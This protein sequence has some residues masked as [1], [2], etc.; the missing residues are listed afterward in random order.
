[1]SVAG[2][3]FRSTAWSLFRDCA[4]VRE[5]VKALQRGMRTSA[6][7]IARNTPCPF[8][9]CINKCRLGV[10]GG[11]SSNLS[12]RNRAFRPLHHAEAA[13]S[14]AT[15]ARRQNTN[16]RLRPSFQTAPPRRRDRLQPS[17]EEERLISRPAQKR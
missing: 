16:A 4:T 14:N 7:D 1:L 2:T 3:E 6:R 13:G 10:S 15:H 11:C 12:K 17:G 8:D 9:I 5:A